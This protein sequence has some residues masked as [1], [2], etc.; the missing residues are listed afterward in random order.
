[1][2]REEAYE[3]LLHRFQQPNNMDKRIEAEKEMGIGICWHLNRA[4]EM[5]AKI[6]EAEEPIKTLYKD[7]FNVS[8]RDVQR[9]M[10]EQGWA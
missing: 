1:M 9:M 3:Q 10:D 6:P 4:K 7:T 8:I 2:T 5:L